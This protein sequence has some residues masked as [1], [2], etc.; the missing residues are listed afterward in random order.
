MAAE[1]LLIKA[2]VC[3]VVKKYHL[4]LT[5]KER[6]KCLSGRLDCK[7]DREPSPFG[8]PSKMSSLWRS[9][10]SSIK[11]AADSCLDCIADSDRCERVA[12]YLS[13]APSQGW[14][15]PNW[16]EVVWLSWAALL[17]WGGC[18]DSMRSWKVSASEKSA[19]LGLLHLLSRPQPRGQER[20]QREPTWRDTARSYCQNC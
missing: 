8:L 1:Q 15:A 18:M 6:G 4:I 17:L 7:K 14:T 3:K 16:D 20:S 13:L 19:E 11:S 12:I 2:F 10:V 5:F 9:L